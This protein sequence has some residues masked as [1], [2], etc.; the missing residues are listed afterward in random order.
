MTTRFALLFI[1]LIFI[2]GW[3]LSGTMDDTLAVDLIEIPVMENSLMEDS[4]SADV[5]PTLSGPETTEALEYPVVR[6]RAFEFGE[7]LT[8][9]IRYGF[10]RAGTAEM[11]VMA[12]IDSSGR[13][14]YHIQTTAR[15][16]S[17]F[18]WIYKVDDVVNSFVD[19]R[20]FYPLRF[21]KKLREGS[22][23]ADLFVDYFHQDSLARVEFIR[24]DKNRKPKIYTVRIPPFVQDILSAFYFIRTQ[25]LEVGQPIFLSNHEKD[26]VYDLEVRILKR[27]TV[28]VSAGKFRCLEVE[29][30]LQGDEALF[31]QKGKMTIWLTDDERKIPVLMK[32]KI[33]V[34]SITTELIDIK[35]VTKDIPAKLD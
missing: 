19:F 3:A 27:E 26:K 12:K 6:N 20:G 1:A 13:K 28:K 23:K 5:D 33:I 22:Y 24:I 17:S 35:G 21:E 14:L 32:T 30:M 16:L 4:V 2:T 9:K 15:S 8:F 34:G 7:H 10:I 18:D 29:P 25:D 11:K 31:K